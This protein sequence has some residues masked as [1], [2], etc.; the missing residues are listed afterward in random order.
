MIVELIGAGNKA[1]DIMMKKF[2]ITASEVLYSIA[3]LHFSIIHCQLSYVYRLLINN[4]SAL[5]FNYS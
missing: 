1:L 5:D 2:L 4:I 3:R